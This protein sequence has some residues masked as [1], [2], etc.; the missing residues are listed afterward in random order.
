[1]FKM[2]HSPNIYRAS[3]YAGH[4]TSFGNRKINQRNRHSF[5]PVFPDTSRVS[6]KQLAMNRKLHRIS[7]LLRQ[8]Q[9]AAGA[10]GFRESYWKGLIPTL[11]P[12]GWAEG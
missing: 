10:Q 2:S 7:T 3:I 4:H 12:T 8:I 9:G 6:Y 5:I 1:M 11:R